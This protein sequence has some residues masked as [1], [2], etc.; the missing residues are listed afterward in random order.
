[1]DII[2]RIP[3][4][5]FIH[6][7][8]DQNNYSRWINLAHVSRVEVFSD[9]LNIYLENGHVTCLDGEN[10]EQFLRELNTLNQ[11]YRVNIA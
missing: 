8:D 7:E 5:Y 10:K 11:R 4:A 3:P 1:M 2:T 9:Q 6:L